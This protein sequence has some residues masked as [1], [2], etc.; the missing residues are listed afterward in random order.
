MVAIPAVRELPPRT[1]RSD[2]DWRRRWCVPESIQHPAKMSALLCRDLFLRYTLP[3]Q[4][5]LDPF[6]GVG[7]TLL[8]V[9]LGR[10][11]VGV[12]L[13]PKF[14]ALAR[15]N[16]ARIRGGLLGVEAG[17]ALVL[18][19]DSRRLPLKTADV[20]VSSPPYADALTGTAEGDERRRQ[21][22]AEKVARGELRHPEGTAV[23]RRTAWGGGTMRAYA[24]GYSPD[25]NNI[26]NL[27]PGD[28][29]A[30]LSSPPYGDVASR[31]RSEEP[32]SRNKDPDLRRKYGTGDT[33]RHVDGYGDHTPGQI[34]DLAHDGVDA[35][36]SSP[37]YA[38]TV[39]AT[40]PAGQIG[41]NGWRVRRH[42]QAEGYGDAPGNLGNLPHAVLTSPPYE[43]SLPNGGI[44]GEAAIHS[45]DGLIRCKKDY[46]GYETEGQIGAERGETYAAA[47][48]AVYR[49][50][51][52]VVRPGGVL[53]LVTGNYVREGAVV[54]LAADTIRLCVA[55]GWTPVERW[56]H[57]KANVSFWRRLHAQQGRPVVTHEDVLVF[58]K[59]YQGWTF[60]ELEPTVLAPAVLERERRNGVRQ[61]SLF[62]EA[63]VGAPTVG[64]GAGGG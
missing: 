48:L 9:Q 53:V 17:W 58:V 55:A 56:R 6:L 62:D 41:P 37:P 26:G 59:G 54:D 15:Q 21:V 43:A 49:E 52:R 30:V 24:T 40:L 14:A 7:T 19:G 11:V 63:G 34:G 38:D 47:C 10:N 22:V 36:V 8:G 3:G 5:V 57:E 2:T 1:Y 50:C 12:E 39:V 45:D 60:R 31:D 35:C 20:V 18:Q 51:H 23:G 64:E 29:D 32:Y 46:Q 27:P 33:N 42:R 44:G 25:P 61:P 16:A 28:V 13:E 4:T